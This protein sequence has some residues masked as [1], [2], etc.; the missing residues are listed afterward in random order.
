M[1]QQIRLTEQQLNE[2]VA[3]C[4]NEILNEGAGWDMLKGAIQGIRNVNRANRA[5]RQ[6]V[7]TAQKDEK[8]AQK[9]L[10]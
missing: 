8:Q 5:D 10:Q 7:R 9:K 4:V 2:M 1:T 3:E 6:A